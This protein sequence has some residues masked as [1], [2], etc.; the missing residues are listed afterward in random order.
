VKRSG[1]MLSFAL[2]LAGGCD[3]NSHYRKLDESAAKQRQR[4]QEAEERRARERAERE[5]LKRAAPAEEAPATEAPGP[6]TWAPPAKAGGWRDRE[7]GK[8]P[9]DSAPPLN[10]ARDR[11]N[12]DRERDRG[13]A[14]ASPAPA[15]ERPRLNIAP[16][17]IPKEDISVPPQLAERTAERKAAPSPDTAAPKPGVYRP[18]AFSG[19]TLQPDR[20]ASPA[21]GGETDKTKD[22]KWVPRRRVAGDG[23][24]GESSERG[25]GGSWG[26][27]R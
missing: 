14:N 18:P 16:R 3:A 9:G 26:P 15:G 7:A 8:R 10:G 5:S 4:E 20:P 13:S 19:R 23:K 22:G 25:S 2:K 1:G 27:R 12:R 6:R 17:T 21:S 24:E 11:D